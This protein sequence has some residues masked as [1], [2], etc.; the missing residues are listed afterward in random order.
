MPKPGAVVAIIDKND[1]LKLQT[2]DIKKYW[3]DKTGGIVDYSIPQV[4]RA[5]VS[6]YHK[7][8]FER[9]PDA[10]NVVNLINVVLDE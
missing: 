3:K 4:I 9:A 1:K 6:D 5:I 2:L 10:I 8:L 7:K